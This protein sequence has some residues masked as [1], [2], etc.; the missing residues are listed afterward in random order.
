MGSDKS[1]EEKDGTPHCPH[2]SFGSGSGSRCWQRNCAL[3]DHKRFQCAY[4]SQALAKAD[5]IEAARVA[6]QV[7]DSATERTGVSGY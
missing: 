2:K 4:L 1:Y 6:G 3:W 5:E 7:A